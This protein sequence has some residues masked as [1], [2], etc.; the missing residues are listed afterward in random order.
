MLVQSTLPAT[1]LPSA[2]SGMR[3]RLEPRGPQSFGD[4]QALVLAISELLGAC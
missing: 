1:W 2:A 3:K 4:H